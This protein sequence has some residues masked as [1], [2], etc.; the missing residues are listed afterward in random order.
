MELPNMTTNITN[1]Q[2]AI[3]CNIHD[4][5]MVLILKYNTFFVHNL[6]F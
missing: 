2:L 6:Q 5:A 3:F 4:L 1:D